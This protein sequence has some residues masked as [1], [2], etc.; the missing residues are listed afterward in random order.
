MVAAV[1]AYSPTARLSGITGA[2]VWNVLPE[3]FETKSD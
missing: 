1:M 3:D 2:M